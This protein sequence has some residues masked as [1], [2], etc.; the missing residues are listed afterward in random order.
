[1]VGATVA[2]RNTGRPWNAGLGATVSVVL[3]AVAKTT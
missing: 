1:L 3:V 2:K